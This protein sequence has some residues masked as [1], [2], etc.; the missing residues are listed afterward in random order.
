MFNHGGYRL[1]TNR[2]GPR[3]EFDNKRRL[4]MPEVAV[5]LSKAD[6]RHGL[7]NRRPLRKS[8]VHEIE[9]PGDVR[10]AAVYAD[11]RASGEDDIDSLLRKVGNHKRAYLRLCHFA[12][13]F[14]KGF[15]RRLGLLRLRRRL[16]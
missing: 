13:W 16:S 4:R 11:G 6:L 10:I 1:S 5:Y 2:Q 7:C 12:H 14:H 9:V 15:P 8:R 3:R